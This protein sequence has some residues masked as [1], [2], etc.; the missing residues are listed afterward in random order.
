MTTNRKSAV[1]PGAIARI[2]YQ[3]TPALLLESGGGAS[4]VVALHGAQLLSWQP[5]SGHEWMYLSPRAEFARGK[6]IRGGVPI[7]FPQFAALGSL[8]KHGVVRTRAWTV[9]E[10]RIEGGQAMLTL[11]LDL[12]AELRA[13]WP[14]ACRVEFTVLL[15]DERIDLELAIDNAGAE[16][17]EFTAALHS[18][19]AIADIEDVMIS[20]L[21]GCT[22]RDTAAADATGV[23]SGDVV[24]VRGEHDRIYFDVPGAVMLDDSGRALGL[25]AENLPDVVVWNPG[26]TKCAGFADLPADAWQ[27]F[28]CVEAGAIGKPVVVP[29]G[30]S[31][32]GR[33]TLLDLSAADDR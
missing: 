33:Q 20:G 13:V 11:T 6:A 29:P 7:C 8:P 12:D 5:A 25:H 21:R 9:A 4:A 22:Y 23:E 26:P 2:E 15:D 18:Y 3:G 27:R 32:F 16:P 19:F 17:L 1:A 30:E 10:E 14:G 31:W 28:V 24:V